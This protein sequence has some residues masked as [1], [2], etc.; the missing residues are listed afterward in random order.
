M[1]DAYAIIMAGGNGE[2]FWPMST[3]ERPKQFVSI[4]GGKPLIRHAADRMRGLISPERTLVIT[5]ERLV[6][7]TRKALPQV[8]RGNIIGE[9]CRRDTAAAVACA[10]GLVKRLGGRDAVGCILT[11]DQLME[12]VVKFRQT[13][14][15][16]IRVASR[17]DAIVTMGI[18]PNYPAT[19]FGYIECGSRM[20]TG[21]PTEFHAVRRFVEKPD[22]KTAKRYLKSGR[23]CWNSGMFIWKASV[24]EG[25]FVQHA[26]DIAGLIGQVESAK[27]VRATLMS[28]YPPLR[29]ISFDYA[30]MEKTRKVVVARSAFKWDDVGS[31]TA[32]PAHFPEDKA[33][34]TCLGNTA[35]MDTNDS[36]VV[37]EDGH[38]TA[39]L[40]MEDVVVVQ[41]SG[42]TLVCAKNRVQDIKK[43]V[44]SLPVR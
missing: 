41:M 5:A 27:S 28:A 39:V 21:T 38:L 26:P 37:S 44:R 43:L 18:K 3:P 14:R 20:A 9:P 1:A 19:G 42:A 29:A 12:P 8:P 30:V 4:F 31:W 34:N 25:A 32:L 11:A 2:R 7:Q 33:G 6:A 17:T 40:G 10:C 15:D 13:L 35:L 36:I 22:E 23:F 24:M 16:A